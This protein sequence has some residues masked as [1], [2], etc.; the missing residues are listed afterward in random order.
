MGE[1][2]SAKAVPL[3]R[4][5]TALA[6]SDPDVR[7]TAIWAVG[8]IEDVSGVDVLAPLVKDGDARVRRMAVWALGEIESGRGLGPRPRSARQRSRREAHRAVGAR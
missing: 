8:E 5:R 6:D 1:I 7:R 4:L 2:E 3:L